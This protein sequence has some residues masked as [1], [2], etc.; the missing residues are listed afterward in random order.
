MKTPSS[1]F[2][3]SLLACFG[4]LALSSCSDSVKIDD[5][6][7]ARHGG[8]NTLTPAQGLNAGVNSTLNDVKNDATLGSGLSGTT[9]NTAQNTL[10]GIQDAPTLPANP[11][12]TQNMPPA[13]PVATNTTL[14]APKGKYPYA[15]P[16]PGDPYHVYSPYDNKKV[17]IRQA[18][19]RSIPSGKIIRAVGETDPNK[20]FIIP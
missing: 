14:K 19:G 5:F 20:K 17:S 6:P 10:A 18:D 8:R 4:L 7:L 11:T 9:E 2:L 16:V 1:L 13:P 3:S 12:A 15:I